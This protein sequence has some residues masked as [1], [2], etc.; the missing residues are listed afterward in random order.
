MVSLSLYHRF[1]SC[2]TNFGKNL[3]AVDKDGRNVSIDEADKSNQYYCPICGQP[4]I[5]KRGEIREHH[6]SHIGSRG[7]IDADYILCSD[8]WSYDK[9]DWHINWQKRFP[10]ECYEKVLSRGNQKHIADIVSKNLV[11][12]FQHSAISIDEF[13]DRN[14][15]YTLCGYSVVWVFDLIR[16]YDDG[17]IADENGGKYHWSYAKKLF[18][19]MELHDEL[20]TVY[21]QFSDGEGQEDSEAY[22]MERVTN[23]YSNFS[24]FDTDEN[25]NFSIAEFV[26][27]ALEEPDRLIVGKQNSND[28]TIALR[29]QR[30]GE[31]GGSTVF[32]LWKPEYLWM[33]VSKITDGTEMIIRGRNG[34]MYRQDHNP[35]GRIVGK[36]SNRR[37]D[38]RYHYSDKFYVVWDAEKPL[39]E[40]KRAQRRESLS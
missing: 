26:K 18:R 21:F 39:W 40:L 3:K 28:K 14:N 4:L 36:Y 24:V 32:E 35:H 17:K 29:I 10:V 13:R 2:P 33:I 23:S 11:I 38:G 5:Q 15:F 31:T 12:E 16:E 22:V 8:K 27:C 25:N 7:N 19:E 1:H 34:E 9:S 30:T 37:Y 6:F 20:A